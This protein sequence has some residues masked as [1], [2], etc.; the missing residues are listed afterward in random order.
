MIICRLKKV[1][2]TPD[3]QWKYVGKTDPVS[4]SDVPTLVKE[5]RESFFTHKYVYVID[6]DV[7]H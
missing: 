6:S 4:L 5:M 7:Y 2:V 1:P 3:K